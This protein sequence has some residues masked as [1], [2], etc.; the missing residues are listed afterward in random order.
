MYI[1]GQ[2]NA[3]RRIF[4]VRLSID[5]QLPADL[6]PPAPHVAIDSRLFSP[7]SSFFFPARRDSYGRDI[8]ISCIPRELD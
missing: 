3:G 7:V 8:G 4:I 5:C 1:Y 6:S 2:Q